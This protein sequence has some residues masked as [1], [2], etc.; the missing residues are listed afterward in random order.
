MFKQRLITL[1]ILGPAVIAAILYANSWLLAG[2]VTLL[3]LAASWEWA[4]LVPIISVRNKLLFVLVL[5]LLTGLC[6]YSLRYWIIVGLLV[7]IPIL[8]AVLTYPATQPIWGKPVVVGAICYLLLPLL[9]VTVVALF[10][11]QQGRALIIYIV[12][13]IWAADIGAYVFGKRVGRH[14][15]IPLVSP[16]KTVEGTIGGFWLAIVIAVVGYIYFR[17]PVIVAWYVT[18]AFAAMIS[19]L[20][21]LS[22]SLLKRRCLIKDTGHLF[23]GHGG[24]LD[25]L[26]SVLAALPLFYV[27]LQLTGL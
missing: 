15:L 9:G 17:P 7:W 11:H 6:Y 3:L 1:L 10:Q 20:G 14:K 24:V 4:Q 26:D 21:D 19:V 2:L 12:G 5:L 25:R 8:W 23:P 18:A 16:G 13:L 22:I 27:G